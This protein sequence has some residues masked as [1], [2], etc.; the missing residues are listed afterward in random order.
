MSTTLTIEVPVHFHRV[1]P[2]QP[3]GVALRQRT[4]PS[5]PPGRVPRVARLMALALRFDEL[6]RTGQVGQLQRV[7]VAGP[8]D[9]GTH[10]PDRELAVPGPGHS[11]SAAVSAADLA[12]PR[13]HH[14]GRPDADRRRI[15]LA[16]ATPPVA[17]T[18]CRRKPPRPARPAAHGWPTDRPRWPTSRPGRP[19]GHPGPTKRREAPTRG[20][21]GPLGR[22]TGCY[23]ASRRANLPRSVFTKRP[24]L[25]WFAVL[26]AGR[27]TAWRR[28]CVLW[29][30]SSSPGPPSPRSTPDSSWSGRSPQHF[31]K[32]SAKSPH[33]AA[34]AQ[35]RPA[36]DR[37]ANVRPRR[38]PT[39]WLG[40]GTTGRHR[41]G[42]ACRLLLQDA[43]LP[44]GPF[45]ANFRR[46]FG[47]LSAYLSG[48]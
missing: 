33:A 17:A 5:L 25:P 45:A 29:G 35:T 22:W 39:A 14:P 7:G 24:V 42:R 6:V 44:E 26:E 23:T 43:I 40:F 1:W 47:E 13:S 48:R 10:Q 41:D 3:Q 36:E 27:S 46:T 37:I 32:N 9:A 16:Q 2:G 31:V 19:G 34:A 28:V 11:G 38:L 30:C 18:A 15:R 4:Q 8:R 21:C 12:R 20:A